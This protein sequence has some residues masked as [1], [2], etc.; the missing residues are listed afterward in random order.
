M[1]EQRLMDGKRRWPL[2]FCVDPLI[3]SDSL[4]RLASEIAAV[5]QGPGA[6]SRFREKVGCWCKDWRCRDRAEKKW[7]QRY[8]EHARQVQGDDRLQNK[9]AGP[10][11]SGWCFVEVQPPRKSAGQVHLPAVIGG[12][13]PPELL[14]ENR[15]DAGYPLPL[16]GPNCVLTL[17]EKYALLAA[18]HDE[19][20]HGTT[21]LDPWQDSPDDPEGWPYRALRNTT[22]G[23]P[24]GD[25]EHVRAILGEVRRDLEQNPPSAKGERKGKGGK[26]PVRQAEAR[27][28]EQLV[29]K[30][31]K[32][33][34]ADVRQKV[35][36]EDN[37]VSLDYL[38]KCITWA[39]QRR[40]RKGDS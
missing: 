26:P 28:R 39:A 37:D 34:E 11:G 1:P 38:T 30:W 13:V 18:V 22:R 23:L 5:T 6:I 24:A 17:A 10:P 29:Q 36:C 19:G 4:T 27:K 40:R 16:P 8:N 21:K 3:D 9:D 32:A 35:F 20:L 12:W 33:K 14:P 15:P 7:W 31:R 2:P 25:K